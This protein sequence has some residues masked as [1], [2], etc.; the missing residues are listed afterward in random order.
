MFI[1][2]AYSPPAYI[3]FEKQ[4]IASAD[5]NNQ[6][7]GINNFVSL[8]D[9]QRALSYTTENTTLVAN[10]D[11][12]VP[13]DTSSGSVQ[14]TLPAGVN[15]T[16]QPIVVKKVSADFNVV[17]VVRDPATTDVIERP[18]LNLTTPTST[19][20]TIVANQEFVAWYPTLMSGVYH[21]RIVNYFFPSQF[22]RF[23]AGRTSAQGPTTASVFNKIL[24]NAENYDI[25]N[26]F[27][28]ANSRFVAPFNCIFDFSMNAEVAAGSSAD[29]VLSS[30]YDN[31]STNVELSRGGRHTTASVVALNNSGKGVYVPSGHRVEAH[32]FTSVA[33]TIAGNPGGVWTWFEGQITGRYTA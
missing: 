23:R 20:A 22:F 11:V 25:G 1:N 21:W 19:S 12:Y 31:T 29:L 15:Q 14:I 7:Q 16:I 10:R 32:L 2:Q 26:I 5:V 17:V 27:D 4:I 30:Y 9:D 28:L 3:P 8:T 18:G 6:T 33:K 24:F 13:V